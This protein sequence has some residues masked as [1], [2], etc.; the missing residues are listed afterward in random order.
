[1]F[2]AE[3]S[4]ALAGVMKGLE[5]QLSSRRDEWSIA[6]TRTLFDALLPVEGTRKKSA[7]HE[8]RWLSLAGFCLRPGTGAQLDHWRTKQLWR[9]FNE[10]LHF[11]KQEACRLAW[12]I[13]WRRVA[14][15]MTEG[16]QGQIFDRLAQLFLPGT[17]QKKRWYRVKPSEQ[18]AA[19]MVR[20]LANLE[21]LTPAQKQKLGDELVRRAQQAEGAQQSLYIWALGRIGCRTPLYGPLNCVVPPDKVGLWIRALLDIEW[22]DPEKAAFPVAQLGRRTG[23]RSRD[24]EEPLREQLVERLMQIP[25]GERKAHLVREVVSLEA[26]EQRVALGD[27]LPAGLRL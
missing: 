26:R 21:R 9:V 17:K 19:E 4:A 24:V 3:K 23:D 5:K 14:G 27:T 20:T 25:G 18:E 2:Q 11:E 16:Q 10:G 7:D 15:G 6:T 12:W 13:V 1:M 22:V 8:A